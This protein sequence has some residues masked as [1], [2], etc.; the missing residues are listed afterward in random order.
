LWFDKGIY[1]GFNSWRTITIRFFKNKGDIMNIGQ[2]VKIRMIDKNY[3]NPYVG[4]KGEIISKTE[5]D[6]IPHYQVKV[7]PFENLPEVTLTLFENEL[8]LD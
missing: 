1:C 5:Q 3:E 6:P 4:R 2:K 8:L 7:Y